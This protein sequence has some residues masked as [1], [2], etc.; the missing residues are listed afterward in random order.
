[1]KMPKEFDAALKRRAKYAEK[2]D[3]ACYEVDTFIH[4]FELDDMLDDSVYLTGCEIYVNPRL[5]EWA[6][7]KAFNKK[8]SKR[9]TDYYAI[10]KGRR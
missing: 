3:E 5:A 7:R 1:M 2:L 4:R 9:R 6:I 8:Y 10:P